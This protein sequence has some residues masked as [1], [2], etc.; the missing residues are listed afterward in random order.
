MTANRRALIEFAATLARKSEAP[1]WGEGKGIVPIADEMARLAKR[2]HTRYE[3]RCNE[4]LPGNFTDRMEAR[5]TALCKEI[6]CEPY[7]QRDPR[8]APVWLIFPDA[9]K[10]GQDIDAYYNICGVYVPY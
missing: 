7:F 3:R 4:D 2:L 5:I 9:L 1:L 8:G 6:G 10:P